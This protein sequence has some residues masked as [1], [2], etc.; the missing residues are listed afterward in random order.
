[1]GEWLYI[2]EGKKAKN[3]TLKTSTDQFCL[4]KNIKVKKCKDWHS[5][6]ET[7]KSHVLE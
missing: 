3:I 7:I 2:F 1:M 6:Y 4:I 5:Y